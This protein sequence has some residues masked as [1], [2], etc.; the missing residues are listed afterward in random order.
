M[1]RITG[2]SHAGR[3]RVIKILLI[4]QACIKVKETVVT[5]KALDFDTTG[6]DTGARNLRVGERH[7]EQKINLGLKT[8]KKCRLRLEFSHSRQPTTGQDTAAGSKVL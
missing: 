6:M 4:G 2:L 7:D 8:R 3:K 5:Y 1:N